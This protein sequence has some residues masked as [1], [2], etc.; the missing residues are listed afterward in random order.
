MLLVNWREC[1]H[2]LVFI[3]SSRREHRTET[4]YRRVV[5]LQTETRC[6]ENYTCIDIDRLNHIESAQ[7]AACSYSAR[8]SMR[9]EKEIT[10]SCW[11]LSRS[12]TLSLTSFSHKRSH[13]PLTLSPNID[14]ITT[15]LGFKRPKYSCCEYSIQSIKRLLLSR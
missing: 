7:I 15:T 1:L 9:C 6:I 10:W 11:V 8:V 12:G 2:A 13:C 5:H 4:L 3:V 14:L